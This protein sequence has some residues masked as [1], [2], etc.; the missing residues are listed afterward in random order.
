MTHKHGVTILWGQVHEPGEAAK[1]YKFATEVELQA[2]LLGVEEAVGWMQ[3]REVE[4]GYVVPSDEEDED[5][6]DEVE[7]DDEDDAH[8]PPGRRRRGDGREDL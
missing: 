8:P 4:E 3:H 7:Y 2:F 6:G 1:T 5:E